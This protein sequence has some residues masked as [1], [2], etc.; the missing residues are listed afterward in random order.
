M[1]DRRVLGRQT[2]GWQTLGRRT[3]GRRALLG[4]TL[5]AAVPGLPRAEQYSDTLRVTWNDRLVGLDPYG[6]ALRSELMLAHEVWD[7]LLDRD[8]ETFALQ[9][10][11]AS[12]WRWADDASLEFTLRPGVW[13][14]DATPFGADDVLYSVRMAL[15]RI[16]LAIPGNYAWLDGAE[17]VADDVVR[18][19]LAHRFAAAPD[20]VALVLPIFP[21]ALHRSLGPEAFARAPVGTG[22]YRVTAIGDDD[23]RI[24]LRRWAPPTG[25]PP[26]GSSRIAR[27]SIT[28]TDDAAGP[29]NDLVSGRADWISGLTPEQFQAV[30]TAAEL[31]A[32]RREGL[33]LVYL[34]LDAAG[35]SGVGPLTRPL[36][37]QAIFHA[38]DRETLAE[39][40]VPGGGR[41]PDAA[42]YPS[43]FGCDA[44]AVVP[45]G[46]DR[47]RARSL[48]AQAGL[49]D[50]FRT[51]LVTAERPDLAA[52]VVADLAAIGIAA[53][54]VTLSAAA[55][56]AQQA[57]GQAP[58]FLG[59]WGSS[60]L[61]DVSAF[62][63][64]F[65]DGGDQDYARDPEIIDLI[66]SSGAAADADTR[67]ALSAQALG[68]IA[69]RALWLPLFTEA[70]TYGIAR[71]LSFHPTTDELPR[72]YRTS[73]R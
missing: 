61:N 58:L 41:V 27:I 31:Q 51:L 55:A 8:P 3:L 50:G 47:E 2:L 4:A 34:S 67:R 14:H 71:S 70:A 56:L 32:L 29:F 20:Y 53:D 68:L 54:V 43:Q 24:E 15:S 38:I 28:Q 66:V 9:P 11:L 36:V 35:R 48:M 1:L 63:P 46:L 69:Q 37:R 72:F 73:W 16:D 18:L 62:L 6:S 44:S 57:A 5:A 30:D 49:G 42:C 59:S 25:A 21:A 45:R 52:A 10:L 7:G 13:F 64:R 33:R 39:T 19:H 65:F 12:A 22:P 17:Q 60:S 40:M 23:R 26:K